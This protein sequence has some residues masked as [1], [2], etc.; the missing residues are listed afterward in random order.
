MAFL[1]GC[2]TGNVVIL[3]LLLG[4]LHPKMVAAKPQIKEQCVDVI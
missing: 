2:R 3:S 1:G 4:S